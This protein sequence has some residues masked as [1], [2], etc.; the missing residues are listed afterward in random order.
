MKDWKNKNKNYNDKVVS[1]IYYNVWYWRGPHSTAKWWGM[2]FHLLCADEAYNQSDNS[3]WGFN[4]KSMSTRKQTGGAYEVLKGL[5]LMPRALTTRVDKPFSTFIGGRGQLPQQ[6]MHL[7]LAKRYIIERT[8]ARY[9]SALHRPSLSCSL[10]HI[11][12]FID[13]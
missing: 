5:T 11:F 10:T 6:S 7:S 13:I 8:R 2:D 12:F 1:Q 4:R 3:S 9:L